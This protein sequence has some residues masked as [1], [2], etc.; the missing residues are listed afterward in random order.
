MTSTPATAN[1]KIS[2]LPWLRALALCAWGALILYFHFAGRMSLFLAPGFR[3]LAVAAGIILPLLGLALLWAGRGAVCGD[4]S[5]DHR[6]ESLSP[7]GKVMTTLL[8]LLI[9]ASG[10]ASPESF[11]VSTILNRMPGSGERAVAPPG[12]RGS[13]GKEAQPEGLLTEWSDEPPLP[14]TVPAED[15]AGSDA[16]FDPQ[17]ILQR[18]ESGRIEADITD[19]WAAAADPGFRRFIEGQTVLVRGQFLRQR[20]G[21]A[22]KDAREGFKL[23]RMLI[24]CCAADA[25]PV[26]VPVV[27]LAA[28][29][30]TKEMDWLQIEGRLALRMENGEH[31]PLLE[32][33]AIQKSTQPEEVYLF[34]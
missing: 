13:A 32:A 23:V 31:I 9:G 6:G 3:P 2:S 25:Q 27:G 16:Q 26:S 15:P 4:P 10:F 8:V 33:R 20:A 19:L 29:D 22:V 5:C 11:G 14:G 34:Y 1:P 17:P 21:G 28:P 12:M 18:D 7:T 24:T 30:E